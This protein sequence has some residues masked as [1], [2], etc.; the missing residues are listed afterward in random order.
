MFELITLI[1]FATAIL[2]LLETCLKLYQAWTASK[3][4]DKNSQDDQI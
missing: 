1:A 2:N 4:T 3:V